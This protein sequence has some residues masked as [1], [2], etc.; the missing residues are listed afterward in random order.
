MKVVAV[1]CVV[2]VVVAGGLVLAGLLGAVDVG[3]DEE[4][5]ALT[6]WYLERVRES[7][8]HSRIDEVDVPLLEEEGRIRS[9]AVSYQE[10]CA[11][12]HGA[13]GVERSVVGRGLNPEPPDLG[14]LEMSDREDLAEAFWVVK[15]GVRMTGMPSFG[16]THADDDLWNVV[17]FVGELPDLSPDRYRTMLREAGVTLETTGGHAHGPGGHGE[18]GSGDEDQQDAGTH[19]SHDGHSHGDGHG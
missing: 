17:A 5:S 3:A 18:T 14:E 19:E 10:M 6:R 2:V 4:H 7:S 9:G 1:V 13:P 16:L 15:H 11:G 12:C 8:I